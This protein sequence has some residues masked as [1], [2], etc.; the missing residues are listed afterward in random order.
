MENFRKLINSIINYY[1][2]RHTNVHSVI[3]LVLELMVKLGIALIC[4]EPRL[5]LVI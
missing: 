5:G 2:V 4:I 3:I 1:K